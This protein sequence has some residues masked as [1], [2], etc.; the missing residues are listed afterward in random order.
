MLLLSF[1]MVG[2]YFIDSK[3]ILQILNPESISEALR[4]LIGLSKVEVVRNKEVN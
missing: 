3:N 4:K 2:Q 1:I